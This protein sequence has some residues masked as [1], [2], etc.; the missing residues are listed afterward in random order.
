M[1]TKSFFP[2]KLK[3]QAM[4][5]YD[6]DSDLENNT[7]VEGK[8]MGGTSHSLTLENTNTIDTNS[9]MSSSKNR[10]LTLKLKQ[11][12][13]IL[14]QRLSNN[15]V[16]VRKAFLDMDTDYDGYLT[17]EDFAKLIGGSTG[18]S[19]FDYNLL[20]MLIRLKT[21]STNYSINYTEF[22]KWFGAVIEP[23][24]AFYFRHDSQKN[25]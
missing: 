1:F 22:C 12:E 5:N 11:I 19:K 2:T 15:W 6:S 10:D 8:T 21:K 3:E 7:V 17:A 20:R 23:V 16:S 25:P 4:N 13:D 18:S 24:E 14:K 9:V